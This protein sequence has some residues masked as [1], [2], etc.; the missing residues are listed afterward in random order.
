MILVERLDGEARAHVG[1]ALLVGHRLVPHVHAPFVRRDIEQAG[2]L[3]VAHRHPVLAAEKRGRGE[4][5]L[6]L[7]LAGQLGRAAGAVRLDEDRPTGVVDP[8]GPGDILHEGKGVDKAAIHAVEHVEKTVAVGGAVTLVAVGVGEAHHLVDAVEIPALA[9]GGLEVPLDLTRRRIEAD[10]ARGI[11]V[12]AGV[13]FDRLARIAQPAVPR[14]GVARPEDQRVGLGII[15]AAEPC[16]A[17][18]GLPHVARPCRVEPAGHGALLAVER[19]HVALDHRPGPDHLAGLGVAGLHLADDPEF[20]ARIAGDDQ[21]VMD[22]WR[23]GVAVAFLVV[24]DLLVPDHVAGLGVERHEPRVERAEIDLVAVER[25]PAVDHVAARQDALGQPGVVLPQL[26]SGRHVDGVEPRIGAGDVHHPVVHE[27]LRLLPSLL[28]AAQ[29]EGP[30]RDQIFDVVSVESVERAVALQTA[31]HAVG[32]HVPG[33]HGVVG[34]VLVGDLGPCGLGR[35]QRDAGGGDEA[36]HMGLLPGVVA[37][38]AR[39]G[40]PSPPP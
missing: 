4:D 25:G 27:R 36:V 6:A 32:D 9:R 24:G 40:T 30:C 2:V 13:A 20:A 14:R 17:A 29:R 37:P 33:G 38:G 31:A 18:A 19:A 12:V 39:A 35:D 8:L 23:G 22:Q 3:G 15:G 28:F 7:G 5:R 10:A 1:R 34:D 11:E 26:L 21:P 16:R